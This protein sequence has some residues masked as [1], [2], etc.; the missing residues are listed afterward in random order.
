MM[1]MVGLN[2]VR[3]DIRKGYSRFAFRVIEV[4]VKEAAER[5]GDDHADHND[6]FRKNVLVA[7]LS[8]VIMM[9][10]IVSMKNLRGA[11]K[12]RE[13]R[14]ERTAMKVGT[15]RDSMLYTGSLMMVCACACQGRFSRD[16]TL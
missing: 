5:P 11:M 7:I 3:Y 8:M 6:D 1:M 15:G 10:M 9:M 16:C 14:F 13:A 12:R 2:K 4:E